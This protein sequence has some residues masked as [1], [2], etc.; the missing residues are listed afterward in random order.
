MV[1][2]LCCCSKLATQLINQKSKLLWIGH[3]N[4]EHLKAISIPIV[5]DLPGVGQNL[6]D[7]VS[8]AVAHQSI[9]DLQPAATSNIAEAGLFLHTESNLDT[10]PDLQFSQVRF[11]GHIL[12]MLAPDR[13]LRLQSVSPILKVVAVSAYVPLPPKIHL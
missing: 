13:D 8:V 12:P 3:G 2:Q 6:Q 10:V 11:Y 5:V 1:K 7:H 4:A 9:Q